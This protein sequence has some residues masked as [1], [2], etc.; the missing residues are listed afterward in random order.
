MPIQEE[1]REE[2]IQIREP[3]SLQFLK[4]FM[5]PDDDSLPAN[6]QLPSTMTT[7]MAEMAVMETLWAGMI[8]HQLTKADEYC[9]LLPEEL[10]EAYKEKIEIFKKEHYA[11]YPETKK[12]VLAST[13]LRKHI[14]L[15]SLSILG[16]HQKDTKEI[17]QSIIESIGIPGEKND[18]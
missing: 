18:A 14:S 9:K 16:Q 5:N 13:V 4:Q 1:R 17:S 7:P 12:P 15:Y 8:R 11:D 6:S 2:D 3:L 10:Q